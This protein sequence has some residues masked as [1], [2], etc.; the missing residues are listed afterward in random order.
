MSPNDESEPRNCADKDE[1]LERT[2]RRLLDAAEARIRLPVPFEGPPT[3][4]SVAV[5]KEWVVH[6][7]FCLEVAILLAIRRRFDGV[8]MLSGFES[9]YTLGK[10]P[11]PGLLLQLTGY[12]PPPPTS[13]TDTF[14]M[15]INHLDKTHDT[16]VNRWVENHMSTLLEGIFLDAHKIYT[17]RIHKN[18]KLPTVFSR[19]SEQPAAGGGGT[20]HPSQTFERPVKNLPKRRLY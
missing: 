5:G 12:E 17:S 7:R 8:S 18:A 9:T 13:A 10:K 2:M 19:W 15:M 6:G 14:L 16:A 3:P 20:D 1:M 11:V 4:P